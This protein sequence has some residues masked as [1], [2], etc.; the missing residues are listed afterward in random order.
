MTFTSRWSS[1]ALA[2]AAALASLQAAPALAAFDCTFA[3]SYPRQYIAYVVDHD[4][5]TDGTLNDIGWTEVGFSDDFVDI[6]TT[7]APRLRTAMKMRYDETYLYIGTH[8]EETMLAANISWTCHCNDT[9]ADQVIYHDNDFEVFV[10]A[11]GSTH[12]CE[13]ETRHTLGVAALEP[14]HF[15]RGRT[16]P[17]GR[18]TLMPLTC[19]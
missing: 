13:N 6:S 14:P 10:D 7:T 18:R 9:A 17:P 16:W 11:D 19:A 1:A 4:L 15:C 5:V 12:N 8:M 3:S 2:T